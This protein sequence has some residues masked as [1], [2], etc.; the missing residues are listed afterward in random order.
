MSVHFLSP[1]VIHPSPYRGSGLC[2]LCPCPPALLH[3]GCLESQHDL[4]SS[5]AAP[6]RPRSSPCLT[7]ISRPQS[8]SGCIPPITCSQQQLQSPAP[9]CPSL[10]LRAISRSHSFLLTSL[11]L[12]LPI[13]RGTIP[14]LPQAAP[15]PPPCLNFAL[16][17]PS[18]WDTLPP[19]SHSCLSSVHS[20]SN[21]PERLSWTT[22]HPPFLTL[23]AFSL[24]Y[25]LF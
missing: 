10:I 3:C 5:M 17:I 9:A 14:L 23:L 6:C 12:F 15:L 2:C 24:L 7:S 11:P 19:E 13:P 18:A 16:A 22:P 8:L 21:F 4:P 20:N 1:T 25:Y